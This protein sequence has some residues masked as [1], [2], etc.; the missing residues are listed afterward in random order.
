MQFQ[1]N[2]V[3]DSF[4]VPFKKFTTVF[5]KYMHTANLEEHLFT[6]SI[7]NKIYNKQ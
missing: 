3:W 5:Q 6:F 7:C 4:P 1:Q 2:K